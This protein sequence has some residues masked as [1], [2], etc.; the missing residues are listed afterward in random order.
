MKVDKTKM[1]DGTGAKRTTFDRLVSHMD[2]IAEQIIGDLPIT[3]ENI[4]LYIHKTLT[5][6]YSLYPVSSSCFID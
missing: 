2:K 5:N 1:V 6:T 4:I 3:F